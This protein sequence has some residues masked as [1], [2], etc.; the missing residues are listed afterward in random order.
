L[1]RY[2][3]ES[4]PPV[5]GVAG[6]Q[7]CTEPT[8]GTTYPKREILFPLEILDKEVGY[9]RLLNSQD[10]VGIQKKSNPVLPA[11]VLSEQVDRVE[12]AYPKLRMLQRNYF[13][14]RAK[15]PMYIHSIHR[16]TPSRGVND[17]PGIA[18]TV[19]DLIR[20]SSSV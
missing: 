6:Y 8:R 10:H 4:S 20:V 19:S 1:P 7:V 3:A 16:Y 5:R 14:I 15:W 9:P 18:R 17:D 2:R 11:A 12:L 13:L